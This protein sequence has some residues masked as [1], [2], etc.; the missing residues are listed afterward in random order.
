MLHSLQSCEAGEK[1]DSAEAAAAVLPAENA[2]NATL[3]NHNKLIKSE[4]IKKSPHRVYCLTPSS[5]AK[6]AL[7]RERVRLG[8]N[9]H[10]CFKA[11][12]ESVWT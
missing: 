1:A 8:N 4:K 10:R 7:M 9:I 12:S 3:Q 5:F 6:V 11:V 2:A